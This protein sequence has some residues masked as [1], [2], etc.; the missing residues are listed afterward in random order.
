MSSIDKASIG[1]IEE[2]SK[3]LRS[4]REER[5]E[6]GKILVRMDGRMENLEGTVD[7]IE[8]HVEKTNGRVV[9]QEKWSIAHEAA[10]KE[11]FNSMYRFLKWVVAPTVVGLILLA[12]TYALKS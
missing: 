9:E 3:E 6:D 7:R 4:Y 2:V 1:L 10:T 8:A 11:K 5:S 12:T